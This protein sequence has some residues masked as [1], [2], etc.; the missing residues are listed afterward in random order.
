MKPSGNKNEYKVEI[1]S[2]IEFV[3]K[4]NINTKRVLVINEE[5]SIFAKN[6]FLSEMHT[7][8]RKPIRHDDGGQ[9]ATYYVYVQ[10]I[11]K[12]IGRLSGKSTKRR[13]IETEHIHLQTYLFTNCE[14]VLQYER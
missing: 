3:N 14:D 8:N 10:N 7:K 9:R 12:E 4:K 5:T 6:Y 1:E 2:F 11:F 13:L